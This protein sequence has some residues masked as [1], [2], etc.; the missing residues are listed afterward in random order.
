MATPSE[1]IDQYLE[2]PRKL[3]EAVAGLSREQLTARPIAGKWSILEVVAHLADFE[4]ILADR[5]KR[6]AASE[7]PL[8]I[9]ANENDFAARLAYHERDLEEELAVIDAVRTSAA[10]VFR[11]LPAE[12]WQRSGVHSE[13]GLKTLEELMILTVNHIR[14]HLPFVEEKRRAILG[15][16]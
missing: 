8:L 2:G 14:H 11:T 6:V 13:R 16:K 1:L 12:A 4:P 10:R 15:G 7:R 5:M 3:R 9:G